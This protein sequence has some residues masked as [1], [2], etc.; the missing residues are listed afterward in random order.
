MTVLKE[1]KNLWHDIKTSNLLSMYQEIEYF[2]NIDVNIYVNDI[3]GWPK[4][5]KESLGLM[6]FQITNGTIKSFSYYSSLYDYIIILHHLKKVILKHGLQDMNFFLLREDEVFSDYN[7]VINQLLRFPFFRMSKNMTL[8]SLDRKM[9]LLPD[10][11]IL[12]PFRSLYI[13]NELLK[14]IDFEIKIEKVI[15]RGLTTGSQC[16]F[17]S[18]LEQSKHCSRLKLITESYRCNDKIEAQF[19]ASY[20]RIGYNLNNDMCCN[21]KYIYEHF[22]YKYIISQDGHTSAWMRVPWIIQSNSLLLKEEDNTIQWFYYMLKPYYNYIPFYEVINICAFVEYINYINIENIKEIVKNSQY[23]V[24][25]S[26][27]ETSMLE[28]T[29]FILN[30][31]STINKLNNDFVLDAEQYQLLYQSGLNEILLYFAVPFTGYFLDGVEQVKVDNLLA[32]IIIKG[33]FE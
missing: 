21:N 20:V 4:F 31:Y 5:I 24:H 19:S 2:Q 29:A 11:Y 26:F 17:D 16:L 12:D 9:L 8:K 6:G 23:L 1:I 3:H 14:D 13:I 22:K 10:G 7:I 33:W 27:S 28:Y 25:E 32:E 30:S 15:F 18:K